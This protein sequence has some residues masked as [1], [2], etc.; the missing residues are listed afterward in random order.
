MTYYVSRGTLN[1]THSLT[2]SNNFRDIYVN[3]LLKNPV[4]HF[5]ED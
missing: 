3:I 4:S 1:P 2:Q 5:E